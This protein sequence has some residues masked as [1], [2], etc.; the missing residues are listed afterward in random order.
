MFVLS[1]LYCVGAD[2]A[3]DLPHSFP[4]PVVPAGTQMSVAKVEL[5]RYLFYDKRLSGNGT[6]SCATCHRQE[7][8]FTDGR[9]TARGSTGQDHPRSAMSLVNIA[10]ASSLTWS[11]PALHTLEEQ[12]L[13]PMTSQHPVE[14]GFKQLPT[15]PLYRMLFP[16]A[17]PSVKDPFTLTYIADALAAFERT[18]IFARSPYD[19]FYYAGDRAAI[20]DSAQ[21]GQAIFFGEARCSRCHGGIDLTDGE[22]HN[23]GLYNMPGTL[24]YPWPNLGI[25]LRTRKP[26]DAGRFRTPTLRNIALTAPYMHDGSI[27]TLEEVLDH[28]ASGGRVILTGP[29]AGNGHENPYLDSRMEVL[30]LTPQ[31]RADLLAF[32]RSLTDTELTQDPRFSNPW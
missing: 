8:A 2:F 29:Y 10:Y 9:A 25:Y 4:K 17:F 5:G 6:Q 26:Q 3:W 28:Y 27:A 32:L 23:T 24:H 14:L 7:L 15:D 21:R 12:A 13:V 16:K 30:K 19:R 18:I 20:S 11:D 22:Y 31:N 1:A